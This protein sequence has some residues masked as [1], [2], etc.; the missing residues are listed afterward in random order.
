MD[1]VNP[2]AGCGLC[3]KS[4]IIEIDHVDVVREPR[5][6]PVV[7]LLDGDGSVEYESEW[8]KQYRLACGSK[9]PCKLLDGDG[10]CS[11][12]S[13][14]PNAC[15]MFEVGGEHCN[16]LREEHGLPVIDG[17]NSHPEVVF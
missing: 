1:N 10:K 2:C 9:H 7:V 17:P 16:E 15:V 3:C 14:R 13:T 6:L 5:L 8:D 4:L 11:I 12:Y